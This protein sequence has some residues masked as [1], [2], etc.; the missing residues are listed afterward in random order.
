MYEILGHLSKSNGHPKFWR[1]VVRSQVN[2]CN[3][4]PD[5]ALLFSFRI[6]LIWVCIVCIYHFEGVLYLMS[7]GIHLILAYNWARPA[8]LV[9]CKG[10]CFYFFCFFTFILALF[11]PCPSLL[12]PL[13]SILSFFSLSLGDDT[14]WP[15]GVDGSLKP[16]TIKRTW[17]NG[18]D[19]DQMPPNTCHSFS[20][21]WKS[22]NWTFKF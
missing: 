7:W 15:R 11:L 16:N 21:F 19:T 14:K 5:K 8:I 18:V 12:S 13:L 2:L 9:A 3:N 1:R 17:A 6:S 4:A 20:S 22:I 10:V